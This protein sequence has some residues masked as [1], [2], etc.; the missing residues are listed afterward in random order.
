MGVSSAGASW[1]IFFCH[2]FTPCKTSRV[3][4]YN[5]IHPGVFSSW[6]D[7]DGRECIRKILDFRHWEFRLD[8]LPHFLKWM[9]RDGVTVTNGLKMTKLWLKHVL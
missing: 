3:E 5:L 6:S 7:M 9:K 1:L 8:G 4:G 2:H